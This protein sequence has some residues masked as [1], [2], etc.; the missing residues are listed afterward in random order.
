MEEIIE[1]LRL[2]LRSSSSWGEGTRTAALVEEEFDEEALDEET[3]TGLNAIQLGAGRDEV[4]AVFQ[5]ALQ[6]R[7]AGTGAR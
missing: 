6:R 1:W 7:P 3:M 4:I 2:R 5:R